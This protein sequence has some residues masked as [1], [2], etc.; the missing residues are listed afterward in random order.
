MVFIEEKKFYKLIEG[1]FKDNLWEIRFKSVFS[2]SLSLETRKR[3]IKFNIIAIVKLNGSVKQD[4]AN[5][6]T[7]HV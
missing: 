1:G 4:K 6:H 5:I 2:G 7:D 3:W